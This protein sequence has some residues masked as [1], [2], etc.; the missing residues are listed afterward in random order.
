MEILKIFGFRIDGKVLATQK[1]NFD[2]CATK[3]RKI[4]CKT[5]HRFLVICLRHFVQ[6]CLRKHFI[7]EVRA[8]REKL[9][10]KTFSYYRFAMFSLKKDFIMD[11]LTLSWRRPL[12]YRNQSIDFVLQMIDLPPS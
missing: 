10:I 12:S 5:Y 7:S 1:A 8:K 4:S 2:S 6:G 3:F 9:F 11:I